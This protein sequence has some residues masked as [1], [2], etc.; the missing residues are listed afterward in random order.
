[1]NGI[2]LLDMGAL[3]WFLVL[4]GGY[5]YYADRLKVEGRTLLTI[6]RRHRESWMLRMLERDNRVTDSTIMASLMTIIFYRLGI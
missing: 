1:M 6:M 3:V 2:S 5:T 4:W